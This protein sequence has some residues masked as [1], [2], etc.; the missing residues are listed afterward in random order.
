MENDELLLVRATQSSMGEASRPAFDDYHI[1][2]LNILIML[3]A[4][5]HNYL[6]TSPPGPPVAREAFDDLIYMID[7]ILFH[8]DSLRIVMH[9]Y[10]VLVGSTRTTVDWNA[11]SV[12][13]LRD[14]LQSLYSEFIAETKFED[15]CRLLLDLSKLQLV[16][17]GAFYD[18]E[19]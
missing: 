16:Y 6:R 12:Q 7:K 17:A 13:S 9:T 11:I 19:P 2:N 5:I 3:A 15:K 8:V 10:G 18:C 4:E 14:R 1:E